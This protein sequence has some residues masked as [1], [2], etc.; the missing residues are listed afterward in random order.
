MS[1]TIGY[2]KCAS[3]VIVQLQ[4]SK[5]LSGINKNSILGSSN[6]L[7]TALSHSNNSYIYP[8][9]NQLIKPTF[10]PPKNPSGSTKIHSRIVSTNSEKLFLKGHIIVRATSTGISLAVKL[11]NRPTT[12][13]SGPSYTNL[14][15][16]NWPTKNLIVELDSKPCSYPTYMGGDN[17]RD[18]NV[19]YLEEYKWLIPYC[20]TMDEFL[21]PWLPCY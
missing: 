17:V 14:T 20:S 12:W 15:L 9:W 16:V 5:E 1:I 7:C 2:E 6:S 19:L 11:G 10:S 18:N 3:K 8:K 13:V 4:N 21:L